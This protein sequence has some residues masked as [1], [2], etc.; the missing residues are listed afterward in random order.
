MVAGFVLVGGR[1]SRMGR[2]KARLPWN[3][4]LLVQEVANAVSTI[5]GNVA[6]VGEPQRYRDLGIECLPDL[7]RGLGPLAG[8]EAALASG[9]GILNMIVACDMPGLEAHWLSRLLQTARETTADCVVARDIGG[10][11]HPL[12]AV[13]HQNGLPQIRQA[14]EAGELRL[15]DL[16][17]KLATATVEIDK[18]ISNINTPEEWSSWERAQ[19]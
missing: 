11:L 14:L 9:R 13:Y 19:R 4:R 10:A 7:R 2:D 18:T 8:I 16:I 1:S 15:L 17:E 5:A 12:C 6:L 3:S